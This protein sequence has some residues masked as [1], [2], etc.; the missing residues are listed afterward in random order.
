MLCV[1]AVSSSMS[2]PSNLL[3]Q[4]HK[5]I[6]AIVFAVVVAVVSTDFVCML[7]SNWFIE[8]IIFIFSVFAV[9][10]ECRLRFS[11]CE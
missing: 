2:E 3:R 5:I 9:C 8:V 10:C 1:L 11:L 6:V 4:D 7:L